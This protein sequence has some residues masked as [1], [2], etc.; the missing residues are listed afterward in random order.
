MQKILYT[1]LHTG[2]GHIAGAKAVSQAMEEAHHGQVENIMLDAIPPGSKLIRGVLED[3]YRVSVQDQPWMWAMTYEI[4]H[5][6]PLQHLEIFFLRF[7]LKPHLKKVILEKGVTKI[8]NFHFLL[9]QLLHEI[10]VEENLQIPLL[11]I[12][13]DP[14]SVHPFWFIRKD[15]PL[16]AFSK[17]AKEIAVKGG[18][19]EG[20]LHIIP[21]PLKQHFERRIPTNMLPKLKT[22]FGFSPD[23]KLLLMAGGGDGIRGAEKLLKE[24]LTTQLD[25]EI[26]VVCGRNA[27]L[28]ALCEKVAAKYGQGRPT[29]KI[30][31]F[32]DYMYELMNMADVIFSK[33]GASTFME[34]LMLKKPMIIVNYIYGQEEGNVDFTVN[35]NVGYFIK[36]PKKIVEKAKEILNDPSIARGIEDRLEK[37]GLRNG[38]NELMEYVFKL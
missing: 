30:Y 4:N 23:K 12:I 32:V 13:T 21:L 38:T 22:D 28:Q 1:Y 6:K 34:A 36:K 3:G 26:A 11:S 31:G 33:G 37:L 19:P 35:N 10:I 15:R 27:K 17:E 25:A 16:I 18:I 29:V 14:Y 8:V 20:N 24:A 9:I 5:L 7:F 2:A